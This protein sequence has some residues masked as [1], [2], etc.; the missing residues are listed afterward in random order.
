M[1]SVGVTNSFINRWGKTQTD[2]HKEHWFEL[3]KRV[4]LKEKCQHCDMTLEDV[5]KDRGLEDLVIDL[6]KDMK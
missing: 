3:E 4:T 1:K 6:K 2:S 5:M